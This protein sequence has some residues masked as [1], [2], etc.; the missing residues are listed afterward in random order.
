MIQMRQQILE[1]VL[2]NYDY[3]KVKKIYNLTLKYPP[4][5]VIYYITCANWEKSASLTPDNS[6]IRQLYLKAT[7]DY[8]KTDFELWLLWIE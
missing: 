7:Q 1:L 8:G 5:P 2:L 6:A 4:I 3:D